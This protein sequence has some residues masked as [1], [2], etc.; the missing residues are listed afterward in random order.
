MKAVLFSAA[1]L[2]LLQLVFSQPHGNNHRH[3][4]QA[5][6][7]VVTD[8]DYV[9]VASYQVIVYVDADG[10]PVSTSTIRNTHSHA[11]SVV[12][13]LASVVPAVTTSVAAPLVVAAS[14]KSSSAP[15]STSS[16]KSS[17]SQGPGF[18]SA[19]AY[20]PY[21]NDGTCKS[22]SQ[23]AADFG[24]ITGYDV[25]RLY[26]VDC[27]QVATVLAAAKPKG[28]QLFV[29]I[30][31][32]TQIASAVSTISSAVGSDWS[33]INTVSVGNE[34]VNSGSA[35]VSDVVAAIATARAAL[36]AAGYTG[37]V[38]TVDTMVAMSNNIELCT[39]SDYCAINC[40]PFFDGGV[41]ASGSG[42]FV[43]SWAEKISAAAG[44]KTTVITES[45]W[46]SQGIAN[47]VAVPGKSEQQTAIA[48]LK[49]TFSSNL[50]LFTA[51][52]DMWKTASAATFDAEQYWGVL[53]SAP[54]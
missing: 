41:V 12:A 15:A 2:S 5:R 31:D 18:A 35:S 32:I 7:P 21:N 29:G 43:L 1:A 51:Y 13:S 25:V 42:A 38:V 46:P 10:V 52:N 8:I 23:V 54:S 11:T 30:F 48:S 28:M 45:G 6:A 4:H 39:A 14:S 26:G 9:T 47:G 17:S 22:A 44:G 33:S 20:S 27:D 40:H 49:S 37:P 16:T 19:I 36:K 53:G 34:L 24:G 50:I 3:R